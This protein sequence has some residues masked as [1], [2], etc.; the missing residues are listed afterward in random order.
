MN[1]AARMSSTFVLFMCYTSVEAVDTSVVGSEIIW[2]FVNVGE[3]IW[4]MAEQT[5]MKI[6]FFKF[7][8]TFD[9]I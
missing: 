8:F 1:I 2:N 7:V 6:E 3:S 4:L 9:Q 5:V